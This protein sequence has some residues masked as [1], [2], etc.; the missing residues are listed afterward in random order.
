MEDTSHCLLTPLPDFSRSPLQYLLVLCSRSQ[1]LFPP[2]VLTGVCSGV[3]GV[4]AALCGS[5]FGSPVRE[6]LGLSCTEKGLSS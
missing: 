2:G 1:H 3:G 4:L 6:E 5:R